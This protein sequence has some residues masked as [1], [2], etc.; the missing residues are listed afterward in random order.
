METT[1]K[2][3]RNAVSG[4]VDAVLRSLN[5][6]VS[7]IPMDES[8]ADYRGYLDWVAEDNTPLPADDPVQP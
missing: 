8:N 1:Y 2:L 5:G 6:V 7:W 4:E 3:F